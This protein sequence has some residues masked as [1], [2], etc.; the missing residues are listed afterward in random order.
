MVSRRQQDRAVLSANRAKTILE[1]TDAEV[2]PDGSLD[3]E[4]QARADE[5]QKVQE[6]EIVAA[7]LQGAAEQV[8]DVFGHKVKMKLLSMKEELQAASLAKASQG[9]SA[10][11][12][13]LSTAYFALSCMSIDGIPFYTSIVNDGSEA[14]SRWKVALDYYRPFI[15]KCF[16]CYSK[17]RAEE[18]EK[19]EALG[20]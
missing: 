3:E 19:L 15:E 13:A 20:K 6:Q 10:Y 11:S 14:P 17:M 1:Q 2:T 4:K 5:E 7:C 18:E 9:T 8:F 12:F 16:E